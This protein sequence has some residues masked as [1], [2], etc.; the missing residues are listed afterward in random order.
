MV[1]IGKAIFLRS[2]TLQETADE[3]A[4][5]N[6]CISLAEIAY[7]AKRF[8]VYLARAHRQCTDRREDRPL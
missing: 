1:H 3:L 4:A 8:V 7:L 5:R 2:L 6:V